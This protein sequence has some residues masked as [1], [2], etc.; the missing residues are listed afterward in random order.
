MV[1]SCTM[2]LWVASC[3]VV[4]ALLLTA[5]AAAGPIGPRFTSFLGFDGAFDGVHLSAG[6]DATLGSHVDGRGIA[7][8]ATGGTGLSKFR[9]DPLLPD[10]I[11]EVTKSA[12][13]LVGWRE[14]GSW[15]VA[16]LFLGGAMEGRRIVPA[17]PDPQTGFR[18]GPAVVLDAW[19]KPMD[20]LAVHVFA[21]ATTAYRAA[22][23]R[24]APGYDIHDGI[25]VGPEATLGFHHG[26]LRTRIGLHA[27][28][29]RLG[30]V[31]VRL[32]GGWA[33]DRG[34]RSGPYGALS[35]WRSY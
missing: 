20:R 10:R 28:G 31:R 25:F 9:A 16:T 8:R 14:S 12:R 2:G 6:V 18:F 29:L 34:G 17:L 33:M 15:G 35:A 30:P 21:D 32:S 7:L 13:L 11:V 24:V 19:L 1:H 4:M 22:T 26:T 27:T 23:L 5:T 3:Y